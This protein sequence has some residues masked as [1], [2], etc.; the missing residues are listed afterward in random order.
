MSSSNPKV[1]GMVGQMRKHVPSS[2]ALDM[3]LI[4]IYSCSSLQGNWVGGD[5]DGVVRSE[6]TTTVDCCPGQ[7]TMA[8]GLRGLGWRLEAAGIIR[9]QNTKQIKA[10]AQTRYKFRDYLMV[11]WVL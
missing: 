8:A 11:T 10:Y 6:V 5:D 7:E 1:E 2:I 3:H 9:V 4:Q